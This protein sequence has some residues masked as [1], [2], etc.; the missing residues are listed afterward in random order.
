MFAK[1]PEPRSIASQLVLLFTLAAA[2][3]LTCGLGIF[4]IIVVR[5][6][7]E[8][9]N[10]V[11]GDKI[12]ALRGTLKKGDA[13]LLA[14]EIRGT[15]NGGA[16]QIRLL[17]ATGNVLAQ[18]PSM[19]EQLP[20]GVFPA[21][22]SSAWQFAPQNC[23]RDDKLFSLATTRTGAPA[24]LLLQIAQ[25]RS[26]DEEFSREFG[27]LLA[28]L[29]ALGIVA[30]SFIGIAVTR[31]GLRPL[32][33]MTQ[34]A[35]RIGPTRLNE[36]VAPARWPR[37]LQPL[38]LA[39]DDMLGRLEDSFTRLSQFSADLAHELRTPI[40]NI[41]GEAEVALTRPRATAEYREVIES[42]VAECERLSAI[43][44]NLLFL[45]RAE[46]ADRKVEPTRFD[47][48]AAIE[49]IANY[50]RTL[51]EE[52]RIKILCAGEGDVLAE[53]LLFDRALSNL[54]DNSL[55][56]TSDGGTISIALA[57][58]RKGMEVSVSDSGA[59]IP[60]EHLPR[61]FDRLYRVDPSRSSHGA[62]LGL[63]LVKSIAHLHGGSATIASEFG[64]GTKV[65]L[66]F[67][68]IAEG[69]ASARP[70]LVT[71]GEEDVRKHIPP[72]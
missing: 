53:P 8:E 2:F 42:T 43:V 38:A 69:R 1:R 24:S 32:S 29:L 37:E 63:A 21:A 13:E 31:R 57:P 23:R 44:D 5:H 45:A 35:T 18:T 16:W 48:R 62:G 20:P 50:Y 30:S 68:G 3:L 41:R 56:F 46:A 72:S 60:P 67:P 22:Q 40:A 25:D 61:V 11:L 64:E 47:G 34:A 33:E 7:F 36:R 12:A 19:N 71:S 17:D 15:A 70:A 39:F 54:L 10:A 4:Y 26:T 14:D 27:A 66:V 51:A 65:T 52:R 58:G 6:A 59:G 9:D 28:L 49:K 55:R